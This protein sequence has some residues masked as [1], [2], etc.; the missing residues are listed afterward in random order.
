VEAHIGDI[1]LQHQINVRVSDICRNAIW[2]VVARCQAV[3]LCLG[4][5]QFGIRSEPIIAAAAIVYEFQGSKTTGNALFLVA[6]LIIVVRATRR[7]EAIASAI[8]IEA[9]ICDILFEYHVNV[10]ISYVC[11]KTCWVGVA[12]RQAVGLCLGSPQSGI[13]PKPII[14]AA[15]VVNKPHIA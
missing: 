11:R 8:E 12:Q 5:Q 4:S 7:S 6:S 13:R 9:H 15:A 3:G 10:R 14:A 2:V 1:L